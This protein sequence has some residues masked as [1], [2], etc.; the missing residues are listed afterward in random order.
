MN[1]KLEQIAK[2]IR[3]LKI[4]GA[5]S[6]ALAA[7]T[8]IEAVVKT[9]KARNRTDFINELEHTGEVL[10]ATRP[11][12]VALP[13]AVKKYIKEV[14]ES[15]VKFPALK[16]EAISIGNRF[17]NDV[18]DSVQEIGKIG[19]AL[20]ED[21][22]VILEH[23]HSSTVM[24]VLKEAWS[25]GKK[26]E[27][28]CTETRPWGQGYLSSKELSDFGIPTTLIIDNAVWTFIQQV[29]KVFV[30]ADTITKEGA[31]VNKI[32]TAQIAFLAKEFK[33]PFYV[34]TEMLKLDKNRSAGQIVI[35]ERPVEEIID[36]KKI[37]KVKIR[38]P[39]FDI[40]LPENISRIITENGVFTPSELV[41]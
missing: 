5:V 2:D 37:S 34:C 33:K 40:T 31:V 36:P 6:I 13:N 19:A 12:A 18:T 21:G 7:A 23:C 20:I 38:N 11:S 1:K 32:G 10:I 8:A 4:Q 24:S 9:S 17:I 41:K 25:Q 39:V 15:T 28:F 16:R 29:S 27:V 30:G 14:E 35:E 22:D 3:E 26:F